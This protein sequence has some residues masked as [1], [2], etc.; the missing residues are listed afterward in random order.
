MRAA[1]GRAGPAAAPQ[2]TPGSAGGSV[3]CLGGAG[4][5]VRGPGASPQRH[6]RVPEAERRFLLV[7]PQP[8][9]FSGAGAGAGAAAGLA[10]SACPEQ[11]PRPGSRP[12]VRLRSLGKVP[13]ALLS[14]AR[15]SL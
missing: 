13:P 15:E 3:W 14:A 1:E 2:N 8:A 11:R 4:R 6:L 10:G 9:G 7:S 5:A 12:A